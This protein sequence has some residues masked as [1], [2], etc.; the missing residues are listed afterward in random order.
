MNDVIR[1]TN[2]SCVTQT[3]SAV[4]GGIKNATAGTGPCHTDGGASSERRP[5]SCTGV[6]RANSRRR[7]RRCAWTAEPSEVT[8]SEVSR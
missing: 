1:V 8:G 7:A 4:V 2:A 6:V 3:D 5:P